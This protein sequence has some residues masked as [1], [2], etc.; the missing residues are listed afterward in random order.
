MIILVLRIYDYEDGVFCVGFGGGDAEDAGLL[1]RVRG[2][3][4]REGLGENVRTEGSSRL[5]CC[6]VFLVARID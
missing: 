3:G 2:E 6:H 5:C 4:R 1:I